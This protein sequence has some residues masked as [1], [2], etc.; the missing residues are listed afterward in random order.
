[1][2]QIAL[3][4][5]FSLFSLLDACVC[6]CMCLY[7]LACVYVCVCVCVCE[8]WSEK[9]FD[10][11][12]TPKLSLPEARTSEVNQTFNQLFLH[13]FI[14]FFLTNLIRNVVLI[15]FY[16]CHF[17]VKRHSLGVTGFLLQSRFHQIYFPSNI[18]P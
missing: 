18:K 17:L 2:A 1:M 5:Y 4:K 11:S 3:L 14:L 6:V 7:V 10:A 9:V 15:R 12:L 13:S 16:S 8:G